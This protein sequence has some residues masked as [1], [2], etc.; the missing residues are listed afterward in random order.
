[1]SVEGL[2]PAPVRAALLVCVLLGTGVGW[3]LTISLATIATSTGLAALTVALW[4][5][6]AGSIIL[7]LIVAVRRKRLVLD[8][9]HLEFY[10]VTGFVGTA[11]PHALSFQVA[12]HLPAGNRA[13][14]YALIPMITLCMSILMVI[15]KASLKRFGGIALGLAAMAILLLPGAHIPV[16]D[17][18]FWTAVTLAIAISYA[19]ENVYVGLRRPPRVDGITA[20]WGM[21]TAGALMLIPA[22]WLLGAPMLLPFDASIAEGAI[23]LSTLSH[24][25]AYAG[26]LYMISHGGVVFGSQVSYI[27]TPA[28]II[29]G[30][31]LLGE[32]LTL[33]ISISLALIIAGLALIRPNP[34]K[35]PG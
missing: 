23:L 7:S 18:L 26:L 6:L 2:A 32:Q 14:V 10:V 29:W 1:M 21:T 28:A 24:L 31:V 35:Q 25:L 11:F 27:V 33:G 22:A 4:S 16:E 19:V 5:A 9:A 34:R 20:L 13:I 8:R 15:E 17:E 3:G 30:I 12:M